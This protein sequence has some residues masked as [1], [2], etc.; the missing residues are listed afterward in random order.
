MES[1]LLEISDVVGGDCGCSK[2]HSFLSAG[3]TEEFPLDFEVEEQPLCV[4]CF[5]S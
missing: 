4:A 2:H 3:R 1:D 5:S